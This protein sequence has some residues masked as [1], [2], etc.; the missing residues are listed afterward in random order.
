MSLRQKYL[1]GHS[2]GYESIMSFAFS[3]PLP[4][5]EAVIRI[6]ITSNQEM[7]FAVTVFLFILFAL[8]AKDHSSFCITGNTSYP[9]ETAR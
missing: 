9:A 3:Y 1:D 8:P 4:Q 5:A 7:I 2:G 6:T